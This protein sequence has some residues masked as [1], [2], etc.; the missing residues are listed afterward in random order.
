MRRH[1]GPQA[2]A[3]VTLS[4]RIDALGIRV[5]DSG[6]GPTDAT[7]PVVDGD[8]IAGMRART[9]ALGGTL[10]AGPRPGGGFRIDALLPTKLPSTN[11]TENHT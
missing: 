6:T 11:P 8:G 9:A 3:T 1:A 10:D 4:Y 2:S 5:D 7:A